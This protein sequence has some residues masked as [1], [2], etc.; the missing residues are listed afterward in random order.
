LGGI[1]DKKATP[2]IIKFIDDKDERCRLTVVSAISSLKDKAA[3]PTL[4][5]ALDDKMFTVRSAAMNSL[6]S[7]KT[8]EIAEMLISQY[9]DPDTQY[10]E[11]IIKSLN[12]YLRITA[13]STSTGYEKE[14]YTIMNELQTIA[15]SDNELVRAEAL[16]TLWL[17][18][19]EL[20]KQWV[21]MKLENEFS[22]YV[23]ALF[24]EV[25]NKK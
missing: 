7:Y 8:P 17:R 13:D 25:S 23:K 24:E 15:D 6:Q 14:H 3:V 16:S 18:G 9:H 22:P 2:E 21:E 1:G 11:I 12:N 10:P 5:S 4:I 19:G 20:Q